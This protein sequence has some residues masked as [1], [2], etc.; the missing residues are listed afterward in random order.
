M[1]I[2]F[3]NHTG[4]VS[5]AERMLLMILSRI[6][7]KMFEPCLVCPAEGPLK[8]MTTE[9][10]VEVETLKILD[11]RFTWRVDHLLRYGA[12]FL[13][14]MRD[15]RLKVKNH[16]PD[17]VHANSIR[18]GLVATAATIGLKP[19]IVWHLHDLLPRHP[20]STLIRLYAALSKRTVMLAVSEAVARNFRGA[21]SSLMKDRVSVILNAIDLDRFQPDQ[22]AKRRIRKDLRFR[23]SDFI[24]GTVGQITP[25]KGQLE[26]LSAFRHALAESPNMV[27]LVVGAP[28]FNRD[29]EYLDALKRTAT[30]LGIGNKVRL[31]G[32]RS[33]IGAIMQTLDLL[34]VNSKAEPFGLVILEAMACGTAV[35]AA[36]VDGIPEII[37]HHE[38]G[39]LVSPGDEAALAEGMV[40]L[41]RR[42]EYRA[43]LAD[44]GMQHAEAYFSADRYLVDL[45]A[46]YRS[47]IKKFGSHSMESTSSVTEVA[48]VA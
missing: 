2:L 7:R 16:Q 19:R 36:A 26:L 3:Y 18:S 25:R 35:L 9:L 32:P 21:L 14:V 11:A 1:K 40:N 8:K 12:S 28:L 15:L 42:P 30:E 31:L 10:G 4:Q 17:L 6:D 48:E 38:N 41:G 20:I 23:E 22:L 13:R 27:L 37:Q 44:R 29:H 34:V 46:F 33:D 24:V 43:R 5:G 45:H 39:W 47:R